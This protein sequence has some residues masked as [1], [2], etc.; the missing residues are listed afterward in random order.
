MQNVDHAYLTG[1]LEKLKEI[2]HV[3]HLA[4]YLPYCKHSVNIGYYDFGY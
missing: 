1:L 3:E 2:I 4:H